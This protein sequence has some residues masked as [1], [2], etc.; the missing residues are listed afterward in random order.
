ML[1][2]VTVLVMLVVRIW[3]HRG[4]RAAQPFT[5][6]LAAFALL[7]LAWVAG[8]TP[9]ETGLTTPTSKAFGYA[10]AGVLLLAAAYAVALLIPRLREALRAA[11]ASP[12]PLRTAL[13]SI[14]LATVTF[15]EV[16]FR[17]VLWASL[18]H[19]LGPAWATVL[20]AVL[21][22][23]WHLPPR[24]E[25]LLLV[26]GTVVLTAL[27]GVAF[28]VLRQAG[29]S[30]LVPLAVHWAANGLGVLAVAHARRDRGQGLRPTAP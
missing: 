11:D 17:G 21:F 14:P 20:S 8:L 9:A 29:D 13:V 5:G 18:A 1:T 24:R 12:H 3:N 16:A 22:G 15:E 28:A 30:L 27:A 6:P 4:P 25:R 10:A 7:L 23:L 19:D 26:A 2:A